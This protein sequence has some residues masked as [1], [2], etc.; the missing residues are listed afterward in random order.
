[1]LFVNKGVWTAGIP[2][3]LALAFVLKHSV[4]LLLLFILAHFLLLKIVPAF[5]RYENV[6]MFVMVAFSSVPINI[7]LLRMMAEWGVFYGNIFIL[8]IL[9]GSL[10]YLILLSLEEVVMGVLTRWIWKQQ[11]EPIAEL[12]EEEFCEEG[13]YVSGV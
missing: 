8:N 3:V 6:W 11:E 5:R 13:F 1:M 4:M 12:E 9:R 2:M 10:Y 7:C